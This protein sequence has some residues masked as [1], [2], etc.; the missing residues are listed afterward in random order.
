MKILK[1]ILLILGGIVLFSG[2]S[3]LC[4]WLMIGYEEVAVASGY[5]PERTEITKEDIK[6]IKLPGS[7][8]SDDV[9]QTKEEVIGMY[10]KVN[11]SVPKGSFFYKTALDSPNMMKDQ[12]HTTL[13]KQEVTYDLFTKDVNVNAGHL[14]KGMYVDLY[15]TV[16]K[17]A[18]LSD[19][20]ISGA[21]IAGI[22]NAMGNQI[23]DYESSGTIS[24]L[25]L[26]IREDYVPYL[27][28]ALLTGELSIVV[29]ENCY[30][31]RESYL[32]QEGSV[33]DYLK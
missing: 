7:F 18:V 21:R 3:I 6:V 13:K 10:T 14:A 33:F 25:A 16:N 2:M 24:S 27:N 11:M 8:L 20:L 32:N 4:G 19:L 22:Y 17:D 15:L 28:K 9:F 12:I 26:A 1:K 29:K 23:G 30:A 5:V 31:E